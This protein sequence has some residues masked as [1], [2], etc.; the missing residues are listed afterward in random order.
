[1]DFKKTSTEFASQDVVILVS[2]S[3]SDPYYK[4]H[5]SKLLKFYH[6]YASKL[7]ER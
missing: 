5:F 4:P 3:I 1:M 6:E 7:M 2:P